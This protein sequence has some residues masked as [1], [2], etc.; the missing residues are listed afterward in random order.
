MGSLTVTVGPITGQMSFDNVKG[1]AVIE[2]YIT[3]YR[4]SLFADPDAETP[5]G[6][7]AQEKMNWF[8]SALSA[9]V[10]EAAW[11]QQRR[12]AERAAREAAEATP[13]EWN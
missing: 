10:R 13:P 5:V 9:H 12:D 2:A 11:G 7:T 4:G 3:A 1:Q 6:M 8:I